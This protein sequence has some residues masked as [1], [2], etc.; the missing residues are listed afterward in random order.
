MYIDSFKYN[1]TEI[2]EHNGQKVVRK[3]NIE[4]GK[5][6]K[7]ITVYKHGRKV[8][9]VKK[10]IHL[11]HIHIIKG[12]KFIKGLFDDCKNCNN[13]TRN[14]KTRNNKT[15]NSKTRNNKTRKNK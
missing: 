5:G 2:K 4:N 15:R 12:G 6:S 3:V 1:N 10:P 13:K 9:S 7:S 8:R 11:K 14:N